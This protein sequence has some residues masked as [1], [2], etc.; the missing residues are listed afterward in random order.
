M[1]SQEETPREIDEWA[2]GDPLREW[3]ARE[4]WGKPT[5][6]DDSLFEIMSLQVFQAGLS[7]HMIL[8]RRDA[9]R[10]AF[11]G[12]RIDAVAE[13]GPPDVER[14]LQDS[15]IVR[16]RLKIQ[17]CITN[18]LVVKELQQEHGSF[19]NWFYRVLPGDDLSALQKE[20]RS[21]FKFMGPEI[22]RMW[23]MASGRIPDS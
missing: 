2:R 8:A 19:C 1:A 15:A 11:N 6:D 21:R 3:Y 23:L 14:L 7:W 16:N 18:A 12:W 10:N 5:E 4:V 9:F 17:A 22:A 20:L 13:M